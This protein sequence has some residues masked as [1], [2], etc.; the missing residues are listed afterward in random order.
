MT[1]VVRLVGT[2]RRQLVRLLVWLFGRTGL[3][4]DARTALLGAGGFQRIARIGERLVDVAVRPDLEQGPQTGTDQ[5]TG[6]P[7]FRIV[8]R[9]WQV[10]L[11]PRDDDALVDA[12]IA[13]FAARQTTIA[14][15]RRSDGTVLALK[16][17]EGFGLVRPRDADVEWKTWQPAPAVHEPPP[18]P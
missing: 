10:D 9:G 7:I 12:I 1:S 6:L 14:W 3:D 8:R 18:A 11:R 5:E 13:K 2:D 16:E 17:R 4:S 15:K